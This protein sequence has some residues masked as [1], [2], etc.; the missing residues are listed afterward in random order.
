M[1]DVQKTPD[2]ESNK[3][4]EYIKIENTTFKVTSFYSG[5]I[6]LFD[7]I[8]SALKRDADSVLQQMDNN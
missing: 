7:L 5:K 3:D 4:V 8:K 1:N 2:V 6:S